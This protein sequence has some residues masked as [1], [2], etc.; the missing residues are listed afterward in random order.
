MNKFLCFIQKKS[1]QYAPETL[2]V[3]AKTE[4]IMAKPAIQLTHGLT[5]L[6]LIAAAPLASASGFEA[7][8]KAMANMIY[9]GIYGIVGV[10]AMIVV[11]WQ[12]V[13]GWTGRKSWM[14]I[15]STC[16]WVVAAAASA[17]FVTWLWSKGQGMSFG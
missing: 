17:A 9:K 5:A 13:E 1:Q 16:M 8:G 15:L 12:C 11:L 3:Q 7:E 2:M 4:A 6:F 14:D 10:V